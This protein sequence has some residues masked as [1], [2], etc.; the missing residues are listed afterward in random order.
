MAGVTD[1]RSPPPPRGERCRTAVL[2]DA[3]QEKNSPS[4]DLRKGVRRRRTRFQEE[5][6]SELK[7]T[8]NSLGKKNSDSSESNPNPRKQLG[9]EQYTTLIPNRQ[10][11]KKK[12]TRKQRTNQIHFGFEKKEG[13]PNP[14]PNWVKERR[15]GGL[16]F[17]SKPN[18]KPAIN[19]GRRTMPIPKP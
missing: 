7:P 16:G 6:E 19:C 10:R 12:Q 17:K 15:E 14:N 5:P 9:E 2:A 18:P 8:K 4:S 11:T 1:C 3:R 13:F